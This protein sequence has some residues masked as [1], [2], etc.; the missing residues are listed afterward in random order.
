[1]L[2]NLALFPLTL[3]ALLGLGSALPAVNTASLET[4]ASSDSTPR[5]V[6]YVQTFQYK[7]GTQLSLLPLLQ[8]DT[9]VTHVILAAL[10]I[11]Q[12]PGDITLND[13]PPS[14]SYYDFL[15]PEVKQLQQSGVKVMM[16]MGGAAV[17]SYQRL[18]SDVS[19]LRLFSIAHP[20][21]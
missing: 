11:N 21:S 1:M 14:D 10:H 6:I 7:N 15:W 5:N 17:G 4:S 16:M 2:R 20:E 12:N 18:A 19:P 13:H 9:K 8:Q 3:S